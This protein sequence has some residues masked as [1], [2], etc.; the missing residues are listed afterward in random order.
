MIA[1]DAGHVDGHGLARL[2][3]VTDFLVIALVDNCAAVAH[4]GWCA[5]LVPR[6]EI[7][8]PLTGVGHSQGIV[9]YPADL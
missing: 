9:Q 5:H 6:K 3:H 4:E 7:V 2:H 1:L 8:A